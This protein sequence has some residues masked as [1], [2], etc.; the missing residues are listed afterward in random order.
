MKRT[1]NVMHVLRGVFFAL[2]IGAQFAWAAVPDPVALGAA[3]EAGNVQAVSAWLDQ[4]MNPDT[5]TDRIGTG[6]MVAAWE[7]NIDMMSLFASRGA[8]INKTN[9]FGE[10][11]LQLAAWRGH[12]DAVR[13]L[14]DHG[15]SVKRNGKNWSALHYAVYAGHEDIA[16]LLLDRGADVNGRAP[17]NSTALMMAA[18]TGHEDLAA[19]LLTAGANPALTTDRGETAL[20]WAMRYGNYR[21]AKLVSSSAAFAQAAR[22]PPEAFGPATQSVP[23]PSEIASLLNEIR[24]AQARR[25]PAGELRQRLAEAIARFK[26]AEK[27]EAAKDGQ[28]VAGRR[29]VLHITARRRGG[30]ERAEVVN[31]D[32]PPIVAPNTKTKARR[33][34][35]YDETKLNEFKRLLDQLNRAK[36]EGRP[37]AALRQ[38]VREAYRRLKQQPAPAPGRS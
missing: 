26:A 22:T 32:V 37:T 13:W 36:A 10:Q 16:R 6:L 14:L 24:Q 35:N 3:V 2:L 17:N 5:E 33:L 29:P 31:G 4:G 38:A 19:M 18:L 15:A 28:D 7:G 8:N 25:Q 20:T 30:G 34:A 11:A 1:E 21:I 27:A 12:L 23:A 9:R